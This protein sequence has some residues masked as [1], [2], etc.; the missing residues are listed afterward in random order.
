MHTPPEARSR[1]DKNGG[2]GPHIYLLHSLVNEHDG[3]LQLSMWNRGQELSPAIPLPSSLWKVGGKPACIRQ[4][5]HILAKL[6][7]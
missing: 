5:A 4:G 7:C 1:K 3:F 6:S 2:L